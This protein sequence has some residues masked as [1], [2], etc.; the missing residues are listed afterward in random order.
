MFMSTAL[1]VLCKLVTNNS[2]SIQYYSSATTTLFLLCG[3]CGV[4]IEFAALVQLQ[5]IA[6]RLQQI[7][8][9]LQQTSRTAK[10]N[11]T[12]FPFKTATKLCV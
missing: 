7:A 2:G 8:E 1:A 4:H 5:Q 9:I 6:E 12:Q 11:F 3:R 10:P